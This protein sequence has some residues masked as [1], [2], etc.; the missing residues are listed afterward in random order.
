M[1][2]QY[3]TADIKGGTYFLTVNTYR[4]QPILTAPPVR[5]CLE[6]KGKINPP[7][8]CAG[9]WTIPA[10]TGLSYMYGLHASR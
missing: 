2:P 3:R 4:R 10:R 9:L 5:L 6:A 1:A 8:L 7:P